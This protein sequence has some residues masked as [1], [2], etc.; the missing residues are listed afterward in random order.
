MPARPES[1]PAPLQHKNAKGE[2]CKCRI[3]INHNTPV[4]PHK[5]SDGR[6]CKGPLSFTS[7]LKQEQLKR[8]CGWCGREEGY[9][10][11]EVVVVFKKGLHPEKTKYFIEK[12]FKVKNYSGT[13]AVKD[14]KRFI[15]QKDDIVA[16]TVSIAIAAGNS[17]EWISAFEKRV[18]MVWMASRV[19][20]VSFPSFSSSVDK[21]YTARSSKKENG[22]YGEATHV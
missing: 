21:G 17:E 19:M 3:G 10:P 6:I 20:N 2:P 18:D 4:S 14:N 5:D 22:E 11:T 15:L 1:N 7:D 12:E 16:I 9:H 8:V 13:I